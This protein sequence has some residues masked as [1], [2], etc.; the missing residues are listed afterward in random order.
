MALSAAFNVILL[1]IFSTTAP[2]TEDDYLCLLQQPDVNNTHTIKHKT[3]IKEELEDVRAQVKDDILKFSQL[4]QEKG[5]FTQANA[6]LTTEVETLS[7][8][9][10]ELEKSLGDAASVLEELKK[11]KAQDAFENKEWEGLMPGL[12]K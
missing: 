12:H 6:K 1:L 9:N 8:T 5:H 10:K 7:S 2:A 11:L 3:T 4:N